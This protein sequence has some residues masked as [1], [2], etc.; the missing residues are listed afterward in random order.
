M[1]HEK[2]R[3]NKERTRVVSVSRYYQR[4]KNSTHVAVDKRLAAV[5]VR[6]G[7]NRPSRRHAHSCARCGY[8][9]DAGAVRAQ[10]C[11]PRRKRRSKSR[12]RSSTTTT[13]TTSVRLPVLRRRCL[14]K[15]WCTA[16]AA[17][18]SASGA[19][20]RATRDLRLVS[21]RARGGADTARCLYD[22]TGMREC[23]GCR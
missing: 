20:S 18:V 23:R 9:P 13:T 7:E 8:R 16:T 10:R 17:T 4:K 22:G 15:P 1:V 19:R 21:V 14:G 11:R 5:L 2:Q 6:R 12:P 3:N